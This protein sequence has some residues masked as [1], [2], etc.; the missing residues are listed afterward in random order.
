MTQARKSTGGVSAELADKIAQADWD[1]W[2]ADTDYLTHGIHRY[3]G[4]FIPQIAAQAI[5]LLTRP[6]DVVLDPYCGSGTTLLEAG[7]LGRRAI[8]S[9]L[10][11]L[12][13][14]IARTKTT[15]VPRERLDRLH[16]SMST[17]VAGLEG[18]DL[19]SEPK[20]DDAFEDQRLADPWFTKWFSS[21]VLAD[22]VRIH[23]AISLIDDPA[24]R[25]VALVAFS[26]VLRRSSNAHQGYPNVMYDSRGGTRPR[27]GR[28]FLKCLKAA[29]STVAALEPHAGGLASVD[30]IRA[31]AGDLP[32]QAGS[33]DAVVSHPP[34]IGSIP[35]AEYG[36][37][38]LKWLGEDPKQVDRLLTGGQRQSKHVITRFEEGYRAMLSSS[39]RALR[40]GGTMFLLV[41]NPTIKGQLVDLAE[42]TIKNAH[43]A[44][45]ELMARST[46]AAKNRR[47]NQMGDEIILAFIKAN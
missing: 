22:L 31:D 3:S 23:R 46:R 33:V 43:V 42:M 40:N 10:N 37:L 32:I 30:V 47:S 25:D 26:D 36:A 18:T 6:G 39:Y 9:D 29:C 24:T 8:G 44:G 34:Y 1:F 27:P 4:K 12:A 28:H 20:L 11:P 7:L 14:L 35:Y 2:D 17:L 41:G 21:I 38:S 45:F 19:F 15:P 16:H 13:L 5:S